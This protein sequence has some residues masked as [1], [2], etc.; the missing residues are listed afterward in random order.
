MPKNSS[1]TNPALTSVRTEASSKNGRASAATGTVD[2]SLCLLQYLVDSSQ[3][4]GVTDLAKVFQSSKAT[5]YRHLQALVKHG[6]ARQE[7]STNCYEA[8]IK[9]LILGETLRERFTILTNARKEMSLL[10]EATG[11]AV[12]LSA[13]I[14]GE[15]V[16]LELLQ[17]RTVV[18]FG[19]RPGTKMD[20]H[21]TAHGKVAL[22]Y[23]SPELLDEL[24]Q[25]PLKQ[26]TP[27]TVTDPAILKR[28]IKA[29]QK[30]GWATAAGGIVFGVNGLAAPIFDHRNNYA[31][32]IAVIGSTRLLTAKPKTELINLVMNAAHQVS[33][34]LGNMNPRI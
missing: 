7:T 11:H 15:V 19:V 29:I 30:R 9:L 31:G 13:F 34:A 8:G 12:S 24:T 5:V 32:A 23:G 1:A 27:E 2:M 28:E 21:A 25:R 14:N 26:W 17:G 18:E 33:H 20:F 22:A 3:P 10:R 4:V 6:F 16:I